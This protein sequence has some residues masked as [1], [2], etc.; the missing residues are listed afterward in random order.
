MKKD[1]QKELMNILFNQSKPL[2]TKAL[3]QAIGRSRSLTSNYLNHLAKLGKVEKSDSRPVYWSLAAPDKYLSESHDQIDYFAQFIGSQGSVKEAIKQIKAAVN[4]PP[5]GLPILLNGNSGVG[6]SFLAQLIYKQLHAQNKSC[7]QRFTVFNCADYANN[8]ELMSSLLFGH[9]KGAFTGA[10]S[11]REGLLKTADQGLLFLDEVHRLSYEN[12][13]KLFQFLDKGYFRPLGEEN[14]EV[15]SQVRL[16][17]ATSEDPEKVLLPTFYRRIPLTIKLPDFHQRPYD[18]RIKLVETLFR[19]ESKRLKLPIKIDIGDFE[20]LVNQEYPGNIGSLYNNI[21]LLCAQAFEYQE[22]ADYLL[23]SNQDHINHVLTIDAKKGPSKR[24]EDIEQLIIK[25]LQKVFDQ[26]S[27]YSVRSDFIGFTQDHLNHIDQSNLEPVILYQTLVKACQ[28]I[29]GK[30]IMT[31]SI[32]TFIRF[33]SSYQTYL[34]EIIFPSRIKQQILTDYPRTFSLAREL[35]KGLDPKLY[36]NLV[37]YLSL[38]LLDAVNENLAYHA[39]LVAHGDSTASSIQKVANQ[40]NDDYIFDAI[41]MPFS[42]SVHDIIARV[43]EWMN[44]H[45]GLSG[46][47]MLVDMGSLTTLYKGLKPEIRGELFVIN[48]LSTALALEIGNYL[49]QK[50]SITDFI[51]E[52]EGEFS[53]KVQFFEGFDIQ[54]NIIISSISGEELAVGMADILKKYLNPNIKTIVMNYNELLHL[55][56]Q[57]DINENYFDATYFVLTTTPLDCQGRVKNVNLLEL[58]ENDFDNLSIYFK[59]IVALTDLQVLF[60]DFLKFFSVE[61]LSSRLEFLNPEVIITQVTVVIEKIEDRFQIEL[62]PK[63]NFT[64][65]MHLALMIERIILDPVD[66]ELSVDIHQLRLNN[67]PF[68]NY[69]NTILYPLKQFYR[70]EVNDWEIYSI[71]AMLTSYQESRKEAGRSS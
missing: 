7:S 68:Y 20:F 59:D 33:Y 38:L 36:K 22:N 32:D 60:K 53:P 18:E 70:I 28:A 6:K 29:L 26:A 3:S 5:I 23:I 65:T 47:I 16:V 35:C 4:Y 11:K 58:L 21:Q 51:E 42:A 39:L 62:P 41:N 54:K 12:Q 25:P 44:D 19:K 1:I 24:Q 2:S 64:L 49:I 69:L 63:I 9:V 56:H 14:E 37:W 31:D 52:S 50:R 66:Y 27:I 48:Q 34:Q 45:Q 43:K 57:Q 40:L 17:L 15:Y 55:I 10:D 8:P 13:E 61:G 30:N 46:I 71:Y 67:K